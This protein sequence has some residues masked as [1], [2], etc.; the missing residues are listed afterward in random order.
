M[1]AFFLENS[2]IYLGSQSLGV[3]KPQP[4]VLAKF[5]FQV[6]Q[7]MRPGNMRMT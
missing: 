6:L 2:P 7:A 3:L 5:D 1:E 4:L